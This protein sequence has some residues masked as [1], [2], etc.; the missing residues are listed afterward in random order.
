[1]SLRYFAL[2]LKSP[3]G[4][5]AHDLTVADSTSAAAADAIAI[6]QTQSVQA[7]GANA[8]TNAE[9]I[10]ASQTQS[11]S[12]DGAAAS[13][14]A[15][16][17]DLRFTPEDLF[18]AGENGDFIDPNILASMTVGID[19]TGGTPSVGDPVGRIVGQVNGL[20][21]VAPSNA[22]RPT[23][24]IKQGN[25]I[26]RFDGV[27][28]LI[29]STTTTGFTSASAMGMAGIM[30][31]DEAL[32]VS[33]IRSALAINSGDDFAFGLTLLRP[34]R[35]VG[36]QVWYNNETF[37]QT[38]APPPPAT[39]GVFQNF[40]YTQRAS[41]DHSCYIDGVLKV[42]SSLIKTTKSTLSNLSIGGWSPTQSQFHIGDIGAAIFINR[43]LTV[44][45]VADLQQWEVDRFAPAANDLTLTDSSSDSAADI[46]GVSQT[47]AVGTD[48]ATAGTAADAATIGQTH[49]V[50]VDGAAAD[51]A[52]DGISISQGAVHDLALADAVA[53]AATDTA[54]VSQPHGLAVAD[55]QAGS[56]ADDAGVSQTHAVVGDGAA[57]DAAADAISVSQA[58]PHNLTL[59][60]AA[61][62]SAADAISITQPHGIATEDAAAGAAADDVAVAQTH[63]IFTDDAAT[64]AAAEAVAAQ[65][66]HAL[67]LPPA[68]ADAAAEAIAVTADNTVFLGLADV[69]GA[70]AAD[71][72]AVA[73][74]HGATFDNAFAAAAAGDITINIPTLGIITDPGVLSATIRR[75]LQSATVRR[76]VQSIQ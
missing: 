54:S 7:D 1:M 68:F 50:V 59:S 16:P 44:G 17:I 25:Y 34:F 66:P 40:I 13:A 67:V 6:A 75:A 46:I 76:D 51:A 71:S 18:V 53:G 62:V 29:Q 35:H 42:T 36:M 20:V 64:M 27:D 21:F 24:Q 23:L 31:T 63:T 56:A 70:A 72:I 48:D 22:A 14:A 2:Y 5:P 4:G 39:N 26:L 38:D 61:A 37:Q 15:D 30:S 8:S 47:H 74:T 55:A 41:N 60:D 12:V 73:Q 58:T 69:S 28:D 19:G 43:G 65:Q 33:P 3:A 9:S 11:L 52:A 10:S 32:A 49:A 57:A 45:E